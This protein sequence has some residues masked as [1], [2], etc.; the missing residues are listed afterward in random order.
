MNTASPGPPPP[1]PSPSSAQRGSRSTNVPAQLSSFVGREAEVASLRAAIVE[2]RLV[3]LTGAGGCGKTRL[4]YEVATLELEQSRYREGV[5]C[6]ELAPLGSAELVAHAVA[7]V[8]GLREE[9]GRPMLDTLTE[10]LRTASALVV[11]DNCEHLLDGAATAIETVLQR[12]PGV[13]VIATSREALGVS[14]EVIWRVPS[15]DES[16]AFELFVHRGRSARPTFEP[17]VDERPV[18]AE[19]VSRLDGIPLAIELAAARLRM[20]SPSS[21]AAG[22]DDRFRL[23]SGG[24]R[25]AMSRQQTL[26]ASVAWSYDLLHP[27][28]QQLARR[29]SVMHGFTLEAAEDVAGEDAA[30]RY[31]V[32]DVLTRLVDKSMVQADHAT[33]GQGY[34][35]LETVR[36]YLL[37][38]L[39]ESGE[40]EDVRARHLAYFVSLAENAAPEVALRDGAALL[41]MLESQHANLES[42]LEFADGSGRRESA[43]RLATAMALFWELRGHLGRGGRWLARLLDQTDPEPTVHRARACW[44]AAHIGL[45]A[46]DLETMSVRAPEA[47]ELAERLD[48]D[49]ARARA[50][51]TLGFAT[52]VTTPNEARPLLERSI[53]LG[54]RSGDQWSVLNSHKM[55]TVL[56]WVTGDDVAA[57]E[58]LETLRALA[59]R[60]EAGYFL[61][62]YHGLRGMFLARR[63]DL[64]DARRYLQRAID[65]CDGIGEPITGSMARAWLWAVD[66]AEGEYEAAE[67]SCTA[68]LHRSHATG[69]G[70][71]VADLLAN[72]GQIAI[73]RGDLAQAVS[74]LARNYDDTREHGLPYFVVLPAIVEASARRRLGEHARTRDLLDDIAGLAAG[75]GNQW[76]LARIELER[77]LVAQASGEPNVAARHVHGA[78]V[79]FARMGHRPDV[80][81]SLEAV[82]ALAH[83][84][85]SDAEAV[86]CFAAAAA[87]RAELGI[88][89]VRSDAAAVHAACDMLRASL[90]ADAFATHWAEGSALSM[91]EAVEY[92]SRARGERKRPSSGWASLTPT[93]LRVVE[94]V[95]EGLTNPQIAAKMFVARGTVKVHLGHIFTKLGVTSRSELTAQAVRRLSA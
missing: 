68:L 79:S 8:F 26:E 25:T 61:A 67:R 48:D 10:Q 84:A 18:I 4:A 11:V 82:A 51:N 40:A 29:L 73:G 63:G 12:C 20:M 95:A 24:S 57:T 78:L 53:E 7:A 45:Y 49:W 92:V 71:A 77:G 55:L 21:I 6:V 83:D 80:A 41:A 72:L 32:L 35:F 2:D 17:S 13:R 66:I 28:E 38:R 34:R 42:A 47:V 37:Q 69:G 16:T 75:F 44:A 31:G 86:R 65:L 89:G 19:I 23:L 5:W 70:L 43:L 27:D 74:L 36:Q 56:C 81:A 52:A 91:D 59:T 46:G 30:D 76:M 39:A 85:E 94:L 58:D 90:G 62:W 14:G 33:T 64:A 15:L 9:F 87:L 60:H 50:L 3:S 88:V 93:E 22:I 54:S 1:P